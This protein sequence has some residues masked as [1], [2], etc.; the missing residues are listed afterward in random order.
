MPADSSPESPDH[1]LVDHQ[2]DGRVL[3]PATGYL[4]LVWKTLARSLGLPLEQTPV[5]FEGVTLH[6]AT[7]L[8]RTGE[9]TTGRGQLEE[10]AARL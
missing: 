4:Y 9:S 10:A 5:V 2:I 1:Y 6:Q 7:I 8:P 3:F